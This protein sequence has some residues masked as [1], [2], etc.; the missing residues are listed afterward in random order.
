[1]PRPMRSYDKDAIWKD[2]IAKLEAERD[3]LKRFKEFVHRRLDTAGVETNPDG[4]HSKEGC[5]I[6]DRLDLVFGERDALDKALASALVQASAFLAEIAK[7]RE[8][9]R[10]L[11]EVLTEIA[12]EAGIY[13]GTVEFEKIEKLA[14]DALTKAASAL[15]VKG[16][17]L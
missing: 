6:G 13:S 9:A 17:K 7:L 3:A 8:L 1:M 5:R 11:V 14:E 16:A 2:R 15:G 10:E 4:P 12:V